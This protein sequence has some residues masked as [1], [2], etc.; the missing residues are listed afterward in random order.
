MRA[1]VASSRNEQARF[2]YAPTWFK[3]TGGSREHT[4]GTSTQS[5]RGHTDRESSRIWANPTT[6]ST[7][8]SSHLTF[9]WHMFHPRHSSYI[10]LVLV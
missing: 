4:H 2:Q 6:N 8:R 3:N 1:R 5:Q 10:N 7:H 9:K